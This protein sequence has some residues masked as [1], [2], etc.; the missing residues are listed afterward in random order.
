MNL[1]E[2][3]VSKKVLFTKKE[4]RMKKVIAIIIQVLIFTGT[5][6]IV[7]NQIENNTWIFGFGD[8][9]TFKENTQWILLGA[10][11]LSVIN[12]WF[13]WPKTQVTSTP[14]EKPAESTK[15]AK[16][17]ETNDPVVPKMD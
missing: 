8:I 12:L 7:T 11:C 5:W 1:S 2:A 13:W 14:S 15:S 10:A 3:I 9:E 6:F 4:I 16:V 17:E